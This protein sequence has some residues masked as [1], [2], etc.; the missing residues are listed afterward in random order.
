MLS[1]VID[2]YRLDICF[3]GRQVVISLMISKLSIDEEMT[4]VK[5]AGSE[6][7][8]MAA[9][10]LFLSMGKNTVY[11]GGAGNGSVSSVSTA[12]NKQHLQLILRILSSQTTWIFRSVFNSLSFCNLDCNDLL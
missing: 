5:V 10:P 8:Y 4:C 2:V 3:E 9:K 1:S 12:S 11:C 7:A 6:E